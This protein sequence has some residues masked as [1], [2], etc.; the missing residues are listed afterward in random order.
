MSGSGQLLSFGNTSPHRIALCLPDRPAE[1]L[2]GADKYGPE[3]DMWS[4]GCI[5]AELLVGGLVPLL[6]WP[7]GTA[8]A[9]AGACGS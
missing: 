8:C 5:F 9:R 7:G 2:L 3:I 4:V 6:P 1:L